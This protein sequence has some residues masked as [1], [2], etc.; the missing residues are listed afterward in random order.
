MAEC[1]NQDNSND[2]QSVDPT[3]TQSY[4]SYEIRSNKDG[5]VTPL[6]CTN[7]LPKLLYNS[8]LARSPTIE[9]SLE[10]LGLP[11]ICYVSFKKRI[12]RALALTGYILGE[13]TKYIMIRV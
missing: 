7:L 8:E 4:Y 13:K 2:D 9:L 12:G 3:H 10:F 1:E 11:P 5:T 6:I